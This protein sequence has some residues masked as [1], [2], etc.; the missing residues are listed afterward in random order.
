MS[1]EGEPRSVRLSSTPP[2]LFTLEDKSTTANETRVTKA[3]P[4]TIAGF[5]APRGHHDGTHESGFT[6]ATMFTLLCSQYARMFPAGRHLRSTSLGVA[7]GQTII[8]ATHGCSTRGAV[9]LYRR[10]SCHALPFKL[11]VMSLFDIGVATVFA[12]EFLE[13]GIILGN[14]RTIIN[15]SDEIPEDDKKRKL[16]AVNVAAGAATVVAILMI[17]AVG[18]PL[19]IASKNFDNRV[20][21]IIAGVSKLVAAIAILRLSLNIPVWLGVYEKV[22]LIPRPWT[23]AKADVD[24]KEELLSVREIRFNVAW[25]IWRE[26]RTGTRDQH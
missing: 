25:N 20:A 12:R 7:C 23:K 24:T 1:V 22:P 2:I 9:A 18:I 6:T 4:T 16:N 21:D 14:Y 5:G 11:T 17:L 26:V 19:G 15:K 8:T 10:P 3:T 13:G